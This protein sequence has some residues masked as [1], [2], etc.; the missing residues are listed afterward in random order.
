MAMLPSNCGFPKLFRKLL[1]LSYLDYLY[2][3]RVCLRDSEKHTN[4]LIFKV[5][6]ATFPTC[7]SPVLEFLKTCLT[8]TRDV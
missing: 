7:Y 2:L 5:F 6:P 4:K 1:H 3:L 8:R